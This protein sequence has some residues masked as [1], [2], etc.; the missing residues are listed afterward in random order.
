M[1]RSV[2]REYTDASLWP[3]EGLTR[4]FALKFCGFPL[5][6]LFLLGVLIVD[7]DRVV[8]PLFGVPTMTSL[9]KPEML[10]TLSVVGLHVPN[11]SLVTKRTFWIGGGVLNH[12]DNVAIARAASKVERLNPGIALL[13]PLNECTNVFLKQNPINMRMYV[14][15]KAFLVELALMRKNA[16]VTEAIHHY[17]ALTALDTAVDSM[18]CGLRLGSDF[19]LRIDDS[20]ITINPSVDTIPQPTMPVP[21]HLK[22]SKDT[23]DRLSGQILLCGILGLLPFFF[24]FEPLRHISATVW[25]AFGYLL[26]AAAMLLAATFGPMMAQ[27][28]VAVPLFATLPLWALTDYSYRE[29]VSAP[30]TSKVRLGLLWGTTCATLIALCFR[31]VV[32][33]FVAIAAL[34]LL[35]SFQWSPN[36]IRVMYSDETSNCSGPMEWPLFS[37]VMFSMTRGFLWMAAYAFN[38]PFGQRLFMLTTEVLAFP[39][40]ILLVYPTLIQ[41]AYRA[42]TLNWCDPGYFSKQFILLIFCLASYLLGTLTNMPHIGDAATIVLFFWIPSKMLDINSSSKY[43]L[44][45][46]VFGAAA[47]LYAEAR[48]AVTFPDFIFPTYGIFTT[49][50]YEQFRLF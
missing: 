6:L 43:K 10:T 40:T 4:R 41:A 31:S 11:L 18:G 16:A 38:P 35:I 23:L 49:S 8:E 47:L 15:L 21:V 37:L 46:A 12:P 17:L 7:P 20:L 28:L 42:S 3:A 13:R 19:M 39:V 36:L 1:S 29:G 9:W 22:S 30:V 14:H 45:Y 2:T 5:L 26:A 48:F 25:E 44:R 24:V 27:F 32:I 34:V 50:D 33:G